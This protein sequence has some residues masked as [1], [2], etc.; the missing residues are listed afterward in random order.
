MSTPSR[1]KE[2][3]EA[4]K[5]GKSLLAIMIGEEADEVEEPQEEETED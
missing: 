4:V 2:L 1:K 5:E 3:E